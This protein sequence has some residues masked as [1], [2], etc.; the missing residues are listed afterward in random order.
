[1]GLGAQNGP[2]PLCYHLVVGR[3]RWDG[4][5]SRAE[6]P[7]H[8]PLEPLAPSLVSG[9]GAHSPGDA[10]LSCNLAPGGHRNLLSRGGQERLRPARGSQGP[11]SRG[12]TATRDPPSAH[13]GLPAEPRISPEPACP[14]GP[15][16]TQAPG[17]CPIQPPPSHVDLKQRGVLGH[18]LA[19]P[20]PE[21]R[22]CNAPQGPSLS[23]PSHHLISRSPWHWPG[24]R[25]GHRQDLK[26]DGGVSIPLRHLC[27]GPRPAV[28]L[29]WAWAQQPGN[30]GATGPRSRAAAGRQEP[31][32][33]MRTPDRGLCFPY[34]CAPGE[35]GSLSPAGAQKR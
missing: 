15:G 9:Q 16:G 8:G 11:A 21:Q 32:P 22:A 20:P 14:V 19:C 24:F 25:R 2:P 26:A 29:P 23:P 28:C 35:A 30:A 13:P 27:P 31:S 4:G 5:F 18:A 10:S 6:V 1:M 7:A 33:W 34:C 3:L 12:P 17:R